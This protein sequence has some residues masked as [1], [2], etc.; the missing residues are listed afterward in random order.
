[1]FDTANRPVQTIDAGTNGGRPF[2]APTKPTLYVGAVGSGSSS[3]S[4]PDSARTEPSSISFAADLITIGSQSKKHQQ[5]QRRE[6]ARS[7]RRRRSAPAARRPAIA[8]W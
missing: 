3:T 7:R 6:R 1:V 8:T 5:L 4:I 2:M